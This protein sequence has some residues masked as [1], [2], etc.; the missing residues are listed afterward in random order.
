MFLRRVRPLS[1]ASV[2]L[3]SLLSC[4]RELT[5]PSDGRPY[6]WS[7]FAA[8]ALDPQL[9]LVPGTAHAASDVAPFIRV[10]V[11]LR[12]PDGRTTKDTVV[13]FPFTADSV[14]LSLTFPLPPATPDSG[15][16][17]ALVMAYVNAA[18][19][20]V[21]RGGPLNVTA[22][23]AGTS[24]SSL[25]VQIPITYS[26][27]GANAASVALSPDTG[28]VLAGSST[29]LTA[30]ARD[31]QANVIPNTPVLFTS[32][33]TA[34][35]SVSA[36]GSGMVTWRATRGPVRIVATLLNGPA[37]TSLF[38]VTLPPT[39]FLLVSGDA[40]TAAIGTAL[41]AL[42][43]LRVAASDGIGVPGTVVT[44]AVVTGGGTLTSASTTSGADGLV[45]TGWTLG[46]LVGAQSITATAIGVAGATR[47]LTAT[48]IPGAAVRLE[49][50]TE[51]GTAQVAGIALA[52]PIVVR[53]MDAVGAT[54]T[55]FTGTVVLSLAVNPTNTNPAG[56]L[57]VAAVSGV[58]TFGA[59]QVNA[60]GT[61]YRLA[62]TS[63]ALV[64]DSTTPFAV[65]AG[66]AATGS[67]MTGAGQSGPA[68]TVLP[69]SL[70]VRIVD[71]F[72]NPVAG[73]SVTWT[74]R[75]GG[76]AVSP[77][78]GGT[79]ADGVASTRWTLGPTV[80]TQQVDWTAVGVA[81][82]PFF[83]TATGAAAITWTPVGGGN[84]WHEPTN[85]SGG[86]IPTAADS[87]YIP[88]GTNQPQ[89]STNPVV[90]ALVVD[91]PAVMI[92]SGRLT[93][94]ERLV[95]T[96][97]PGVTCFNTGTQLWIAPI[98]SAEVSARVQC[99][100]VIGGLVRVLGG[101][102]T[103]DNLY[104]ASNGHLDV[105]GSVVQTDLALV[106]ELNG[107][108]EMTDP[109]DSVVVYGN[110]FFRGGNTNGLL[111]AGL[112]ELWGNLNQEGAVSPASFSASGTHLTRFRAEGRQD[113]SFENPGTGA[114]A[115]HFQTLELQK[116][117]G[118]S[119]S[120]VSDVVAAGALI[121]SMTEPAI[122]A[123]FVAN[124][125]LTSAGATVSGLTF[126]NVRWIVRDGAPITAMTSVSFSS[127]PVTV[128]Q[129]DIQRLGG[130]VNLISPTFATV[131][132]G[133]GRY[134]RVA[135]SDG[136]GASVFGVN[137]TGA[138]PTSHADLVT[139]V[140]PATLT[141]WPGLG[142]LIL[143]A[144]IGSAGTN[145]DDVDAAGNAVNLVGSAIDGTAT[146]L[147]AGASGLPTFDFNTAGGADRTTGF[148]R[149]DLLAVRAD[150][151]HDGA[152]LVVDRNNDGSFADESPQP[153][154]GMHANRFITFDLAVIRSN[155]SLPAGQAFQLTGI[156]GPA[157]AAP[158]SG[159]SLAVLLDGAL[160]L[161]H[162][163]AAGATTSNTFSLAVSGAGRYLTFIALEGT[164]LEPN[165][166]H[167][168][169]ARVTLNP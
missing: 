3:L 119:V 59:V 147:A 89:V 144:V 136:G 85:W 46:Q 9:P 67:V 88:G 23:R 66:T 142:G 76:G 97:V 73:V 115:S 127:M 169:F 138:T 111:T 104:I 166:D 109:A 50:T 77:A 131:P 13:E 2:F 156:A 162:D 152:A 17:L 72:G 21:F 60:A 22:R 106:T 108:L 10:R 143:S 78:V 4:G 71:A 141:G 62:A 61:G 44:F 40:Q 128:V 32:T 153:G 98:T 52:P 75:T 155:A 83:A 140:A 80:G 158:T 129:L 148:T 20:T 55:G 65:A 58:A 95:G 56:T 161:M 45:S 11:T 160:L 126:T 146:T 118:G 116:L 101:L 7:G 114:A 19:D 102:A 149:A 5:G 68:S 122:I 91:G 14:A 130:T 64:P 48:G 117:A 26:G 157:N 81:T 41:P 1:A 27:P 37:D 165:F 94:R 159:M 34:R 92:T 121:E 25:P 86:V 12:Q 137:V 15:L 90:R 57:S 16:S 133:A 79:N 103:S 100:V 134:L 33:D 167:G 132:S 35:A 29:L 120:L 24:G 54:A 124:M 145:A 82:S 70:R 99:P 74:V 112:L 93:I 39:Q 151:K 163:V 49:V 105:N 28:T 63:G 110:A 123:S 96:A 107:V 87:V 8:L 53:A 139:V 164:S 69:D 36:P 150:Q 47:T 168:A 31:G 6:G 84:L 43:V 113:I 18:G 51:P 135:D 30:V 42:V 154:F 125:S 38:Q